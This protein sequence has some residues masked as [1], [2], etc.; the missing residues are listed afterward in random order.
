VHAQGRQ[1]CLFMDSKGLVCA[2][3]S[4]LQPHKRP[5]AHDLPFQATLLEAVC[6][7]RPTALVGVS[8]QR[9]AFKPEV[10][11]VRWGDP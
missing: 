11:K 1:R 6:Q 2:S 7:F 10:I 5:F 9:G 8:T 3:R 4:D